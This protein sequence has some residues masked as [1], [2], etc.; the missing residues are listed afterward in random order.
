MSA[1]KKCSHVFLVRL[2][3]ELVGVDLLSASLEDSNGD[4][5]SETK[6]D[7]DD[8][9]TEPQPTSPPDPMQEWQAQH[10]FDNY[11][12]HEDSIATRDL[13]DSYRLSCNP[14]CPTRGRCGKGDSACEHTFPFEFRPPPDRKTCAKCGA[15]CICPPACTLSCVVA[16]SKEPLVC[17]LTV[18]DAVLYTQTRIIPGIKCWV[19]KC[20][21][22]GAA[23]YPHPVDQG[24]FVFQSSC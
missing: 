11:R 8:D 13:V 20:V 14:A 6:A 9:A 15:Q 5:S 21:G 22:C 17:Q 10:Q 7:V 23:Y 16:D 12:I 24:F 2:H 3:L 18:T 1:A 19:S 4:T